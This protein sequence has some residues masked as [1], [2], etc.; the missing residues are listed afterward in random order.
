M[1]HDNYVL[2]LTGAIQKGLIL[3]KKKLFDACVYFLYICV[4]TDFV[5]FGQLVV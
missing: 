3:R 1:V 2:F 5:V 4:R